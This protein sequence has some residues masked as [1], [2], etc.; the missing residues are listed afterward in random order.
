V[1]WRPC[2]FSLSS[3]CR[4]FISVGVSVKNICRQSDRSQKGL[5]IFDCGGS[6]TI[7]KKPDGNSMVYLYEDTIYNQ[8]DE[9]I[10]L[11][12]VFKGP[13]DICLVKIKMFLEICSDLF[14]Q[15]TLSKNQCFFVFFSYFFFGKFFFKFCF[16]KKNDWFFLGKNE[17]Q[18][19]HKISKT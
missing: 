4:Q 15:K 6:F 13:D 9:M 2:F 8:I 18:I 16:L 7:I 3:V 19:S 1:I 5:K 12:K 14:F 10:L 11:M 17:L